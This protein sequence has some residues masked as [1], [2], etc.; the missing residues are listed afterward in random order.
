MY[1]ISV[2]AN[3][4]RPYLT[5]E[6]KG[7]NDYINAVNIDVSI[8]YPGLPYCN[9]RE[10]RGCRNQG[11]GLFL[12][13]DIVVACICLCVSL[14]A[15]VCARKCICVSIM[16]FKLKIHLKIELYLSLSLSVRL[17]SIQHGISKFIP[18][19]LHCTVK[20]SLD[21]ELDELWAL[22]LFVCFFGVEVD[23]RD[24][25]RSWGTHCPA[26]AWLIRLNEDP[27]TAYEFSFN[28]CYFSFILSYF[29]HI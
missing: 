6:V 22:V 25:W 29:L 8:N 2:L 5:S 24:S 12:P 16:S 1:S 7:T 15:C 26:L 19:M 3:Y 23:C 10:R 9:S 11:T 28:S 14:S 20:S 21:F 17:D 13:S 18:E 27:L 4:H